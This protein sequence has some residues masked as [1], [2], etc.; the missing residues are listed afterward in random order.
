M[1]QPGS[2]QM[3]EPIFQAHEKWGI[4]AKAGFQQIPNAL[5]HAQRK[6][7]LD[8][9]DIVV[10]LNLTMH[11]WRKNEL[12]RPRTSVIAQRMGV[13]P[14]TVERHLRKLEDQGLIKSLPPKEIA[15]EKFKV[16]EFDLSGLVDRLEDLSKLELELREYEYPRNLSNRRDA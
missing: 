10:L 7:R 13:S 5:F 9:T 15:E 6:L 2:N 1:A 12:P 14:R 11:W 4:A 8:T 3:P 16:R